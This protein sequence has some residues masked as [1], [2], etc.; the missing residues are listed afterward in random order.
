MSPVAQF[1][2]FPSAI[3]LAKVIPPFTD[4]GIVCAAFALALSV[5]EICIGPIA[6]VP[7]VAQ[8]TVE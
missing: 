3:V 7:G 6:A 8:V 4:N 5:Q 2:V 1:A